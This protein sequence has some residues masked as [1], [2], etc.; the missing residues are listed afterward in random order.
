MQKAKLISS[1]SVVSPAVSCLVIGGALV[2][3]L[4]ASVYL[5]GEWPSASGWLWTGFVMCLLLGICCLGV[6][7]LADEVWD[8][9]DHLVV[10]KG[11]TR[12]R[13]DLRNV[14][15]AEASTNSSPARVTLY[16][17]T[18]CA[19]GRLV[20]FRTAVRVGPTSWKDPLAYQ[21]MERAQAAR[22]AKIEADRLL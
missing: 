8:L 2:A 14:L 5:T 6:L 17:T 21:L 11:G 1:G 7:G 16:L 22:D 13:I 12:V 18:P 19:L 3:V 4:A 20:A 15:K 10:S 9:G